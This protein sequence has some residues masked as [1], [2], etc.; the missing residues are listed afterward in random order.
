MKWFKHLTGS[1]KDPMIADLISEYGGN[2]YLV[3][4]GILDMMAEDYDEDNPGI[5]TF[6]VNYLTRNLHIS[7]KNLRKILTFINNY[8]KKNGKIYHTIN[9]SKITL[10]CPKLKDLVDEWTKKKLR[11]NSGVTTDSLRPIDLDLDLE[12]D[13]KKEKNKKKKPVS[14]KPAHNIFEYT[15]EFLDFWNLYPNGKGKQPAFV[16]WKKVADNKNIIIES[17]KKQLAN[18]LSEFIRDDG[19]YARQASTWLNQRGWEDEIKIL[20]PKGNTHERTTTLV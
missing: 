5:A 9:G 4:F 10:T 18:P 14:T 13:I 8:P 20:Q 1:L 7:Q 15:E 19:K 11:S 2:G 3:F 6:S 17:L 12:E 16:S